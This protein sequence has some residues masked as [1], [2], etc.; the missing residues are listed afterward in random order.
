MTSIRFYHLQTQN[1]DEALPAILEKA[2]EQ[3]HKIMVQM[4][5]EKEVERMTTHLW[6]YKE[7]YFLPHG[8][9]KDGNALE[10]PIWITNST[11]N[12]NQAN[13]L[14]LT[15]GTTNDAITDFDL[16]CEI[17]DGRSHEAVQN[18]RK[19][20]TEYKSKNLDVTY[21]HQSE[22]GKWDKKS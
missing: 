8:S 12:E 14:I 18:A 4:A 10:Q 6:S 20:W 3:N 22:T 13:V 11:N 9:K 19:K 21:W 5:D 2:Y 17:F 16:C 15:Q 7:H 1:L